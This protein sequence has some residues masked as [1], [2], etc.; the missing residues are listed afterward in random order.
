MSHV[1]AAPGAADNQR[2]SNILR[3]VVPSPRHATRPQQQRCTQ[4]S[5]RSA[6]CPR[7]LPLRTGIQCSAQQLSSSLTAVLPSPFPNRTLQRLSH[8]TISHDIPMRPQSCLA[9]ADGDLLCSSAL[10]SRARSRRHGLRARCL[11]HPC[12]STC[13]HSKC[14]FTALQLLH[15]RPHARPV[16]GPAD[17]HLG[18]E[19]HSAGL[20]GLHLLAAV[21]GAKTCAQLLWAPRLRPTRGALHGMRLCTSQSESHTHQPSRHRQCRG[22]LIQALHLQK[23][24][25]DISL[26]LGIHA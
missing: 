2:C 15:R 22:G 12:P 26:A 20:Q 23:H 18:R 25:L 17:A 9:T 13:R 14:L 24:V 3:Y 21:H 11:L 1:C 10:A 19:G 6:A 4:R 16:P 5:V 8:K 7:L